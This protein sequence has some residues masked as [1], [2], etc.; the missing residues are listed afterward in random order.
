MLKKIILTTLCLSLFAAFS[1]EIAHCSEEAIYECY[2]QLLQKYPNVETIRNRFG[3][4]A[5]W[6]ITTELSPHDDSLELEYA[7][8]SYPGIEIEAMEFTWD[9]EDRYFLTSVIVTEAGLTDFLGIDV[10]S[11]EEAVISKFGEPYSAEG[12]E[13]CYEDEAGYCFITFVIE[14]DK[15]AEMRFENFVD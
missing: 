4:G 6:R 1:A 10:G 2:E 15:V 5:R 7:A 13:L 14:S 11:S 8:M 12:N 3:D 9:G